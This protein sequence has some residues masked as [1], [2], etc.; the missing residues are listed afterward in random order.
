MNDKCSQVPPLDNNGQHGGCCP[1]LNWRAVAS[2]AI[3]MW[4]RFSLI[5]DGKATSGWHSFNASD[6]SRLQDACEASR[7]TGTIDYI[8]LAAGALETALVDLDLEWGDYTFTSTRSVDFQETVDHWTDWIV[9]H[10]LALSEPPDKRPALLVDVAR[11]LI[12]RAHTEQRVDEEMRSMK[13]E[14]AY[15]GF[16]PGVD[17][18]LSAMQALSL[19]VSTNPEFGSL[20][21]AGD[22]Q[23][24]LGRIRDINGSKQQFNDI[25]AEI[26]ATLEQITGCG[27]E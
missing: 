24:A 13:S 27:G 8:G 6:A 11:R 12:K 5:L 15:E 14:D 21:T 22:P 17:R 23:P 7:E 4:S 26:D 25:V 2:T 1:D 20:P 10:H 9:H 3:V 16:L 18:A 19:F